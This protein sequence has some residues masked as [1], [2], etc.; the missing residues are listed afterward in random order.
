MD[1]LSLILSGADVIWDN[2]SISLNK[3]IENVQL[4]ASR[5]VTGGTTLVL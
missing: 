4:E 1:G 3:N 2:M 5:I